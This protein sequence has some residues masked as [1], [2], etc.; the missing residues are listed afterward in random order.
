MNPKITF[1]S[2]LLIAP[3]T[4]LYA[5]SLPD[6]GAPPE[7]RVP[8]AVTFTFSDPAGKGDA[9]AWTRSAFREDESWK[10]ASSFG[11][12]EHAMNEAKRKKV[13]FR[14][15]MTTAREVFN[16]T[17]CASK[18]DGIVDLWNE[19]E[20][21]RW[22]IRDDG[23]H[24][25]RYFSYIFRRDEIGKP[26]QYGVIYSLT[27]D[28]PA[29]LDFAFVQDKPYHVPELRDAG[30]TSSKFQLVLDI[31]HI[32]DA[33]AIRGPDDFYY[34]VGTPLLHGKQDG[35]DVF[36]AKDRHGP[37]EKAG[38]PWT[39][40]AATWANKKNL[41]QPNPKDK[42]SDD[43]IIWAP[44]I[45]YIKSLKKWVLVYFPNKAPKP[46]AK[47]FYIGIASSDTPLG[48]YRDIVDHHIADDPD[49]HLF[50]DDDGA[51]YL[52]SGIG[53]IARMKSDLSGLAEE[54]RTIYPRNAQA[55]ANEGTTL[56]K[57]NGVYYF[58]G[59][60][61][62]YYWDKDGKKS[63]TYDCVMCAST[64]GIYGPYGDRYVAIKN[65]GNNSFFR[66]KDGTWC[67]T[68]WQPTKKTTIVAVELAPDGT[69]RPAENYDVLT[70]LIY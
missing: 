42:N 25:V 60:F 19:G 46:L 68:V 62:T 57:H 58:G 6:P 4:L 30:T 45:E 54:P 33:C 65:G 48:P 1:L 50:E 38:T 40:D 61:T 10:K 23:T 36:R 20:R 27:N 13:W 7:P 67:C 53:R 8:L 55:I 31:P 37:F 69:W 15:Q 2:T 5:D 64:N 39:F 47:G 35:I 41:G 24:W 44:E 66:D 22:S 28:G 34:I 70:G 26:T 17:Y 32:R 59:A 9:G 11:E 52:T 14:F 49:P 43:E 63:S 16:N 21:N 51:V 12:I 56:F 3:L 18:H 29:K